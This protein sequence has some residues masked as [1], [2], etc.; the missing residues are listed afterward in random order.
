MGQRSVALASTQT[1]ENVSVRIYV[2]HQVA[3]EAVAVVSTAVLIATAALTVVHRIVR[4]VLLV[5]VHLVHLAVTTKA[6]VRRG[7][8]AGEYVYPSQTSV[9]PSAAQCEFSPSG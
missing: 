7:Q 9:D 4:A 8:S 2:A 6:V 5:V 1:Q 3:A